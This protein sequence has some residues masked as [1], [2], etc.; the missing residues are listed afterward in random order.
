MNAMA[1]INSPLLDA[2]KPKCLN[3]CGYKVIFSI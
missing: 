3:Y 2:E 1:N